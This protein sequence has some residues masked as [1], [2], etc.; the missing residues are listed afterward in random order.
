MTGE[1]FAAKTRAAWIQQSR[2]ALVRM[3]DAGATTLKEGAV[4]DYEAFCLF[5]EA[6]HALGVQIE[7]NLFD[8]AQMGPVE[9]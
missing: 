6:S 1:V 3:Q 4:A 8:L 9:L 7:Q 5:V 2:A